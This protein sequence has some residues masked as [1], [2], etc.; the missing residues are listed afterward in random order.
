M[1]SVEG[2]VTGS[3]LLGRLAERW[4]PTR[5]GDLPP[6]VVE[7]ARHCA[8]DWFGCALAGSREPLAVLLRDELDEGAATIVGLDRTASPRTAALVNGAAGHAL[9]FD[10]THTLLSGHPTAPV[11]PA[12]LG[13]GEELDASGE[14]LLT[15]FVVGV[16]VECRVG[17]LLAPGHYRAG[18]HATGTVGTLGAAAA[19]AR[20][21]GLDGQRTT[22]ALALAATQ[23][24]G[25]K[26]SFGTM[27]KPLHAG[28]AATD[29]LLAA[30]LAG[31]GFTGN[32]GVLEA[33]QGLAAA[34]GGADP[35]PS[36]LD[37]LE[38]RW[39]ILDTLFKHHAACYLTHASIN[40]AL[41]LGVAPDEVQQV[42][43][44]VARDSLQVCDISEP[45]TGLE[46]KFSLRATTAMALLGDETTDMAAYSDAR[47]AAPDLLA[48]RDRVR[49]VPEDE[50]PG[51]RS[52]VVVTTTDGRTLEAEDD[53][54]RPAADLALQWERLSAKFRGLAAPVVGEEGADRLRQAV[55]EAARAR[56]LGKLARP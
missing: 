25:L 44:H 54:G 51:T 41:A 26:A 33:P 21:L 19:C 37:R 4:S 36:R 15:A 10:D 14:D 20:L 9:D 42:D 6:A 53:T 11:L 8:L 16:E 49:V 30:R 50:R 1:G 39:T 3:A 56:T 2:G 46:G 27:A 48:M 24:A 17:A 38:D 12:A 7:V 47:M 45:A 35:D 55:A 23:A 29:G 43:V 34:A 31:R 22:H 52:R 5:F 40:A 13:L 18:W 32:P 28:K